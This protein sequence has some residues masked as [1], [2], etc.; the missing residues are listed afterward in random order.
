MDDE[1][2]KPVVGFEGHYEVSDKGRVRSLKSGT[3]QI[4]KLTST[5]KGYPQVKLCL[6]GEEHMCMV[7]HLV[8]RAFL[9]DPP[10]PI[11]LGGDCYEVNHKDGDPTNNHVNN[12][13]WCSRSENMKHGFEQGNVRPPS[14]DGPVGCTRSDYDSSF[15]GEDNGR[16]ALSESEVKEIRRVYREDEDATHRSLAKQ[17]DVGRS[18]IGRILRN[19]SW[20]HI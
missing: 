20:S 17:F 5:T 8:A 18:T 11:G 9:G 10:G 1:T 16:A 6:D 4:R 19:E 2:W 3:P 13:E 15:N 7:H 12:L 14:L